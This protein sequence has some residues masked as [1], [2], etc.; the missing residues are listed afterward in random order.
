MTRI[1]R[2][3]LV[4]VVVCASTNASSEQSGNRHAPRNAATLRSTVEATRWNAGWALDPRST[5]EGLVALLLE[6][7]ERS[8]RQ[9]ILR[10]LGA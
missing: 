6:P 5:A 3:L 9:K 8:E 4:V 1:L 10:A 2:L 7:D